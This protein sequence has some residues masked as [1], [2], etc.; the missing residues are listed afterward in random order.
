MKF[1]KGNLKRL[2]N[3][4][5]SNQNNNNHIVSERNSLSPSATGKK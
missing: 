4:K 2:L 1:N 5:E 3:L